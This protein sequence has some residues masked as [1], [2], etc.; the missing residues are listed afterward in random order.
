[1]EHNSSTQLGQ[2]ERYAFLWSLARLVIAALSLFF[3]AMPFMY[4]LGLSGLGSFL[5]LFWLVSGV[6][7]LYLGYL[8]YT[9]GMKVFGESDT[10]TKVLFLILVLSGLNLGWASIGGNIGMSIVGYGAFAGI[11]YKLTALVYLYT[12][13]TLWKE[14]KANAE[15]LFA[16][17]ATPAPQPEVTP[18]E[19]K[20]EKPTPEESI[21]VGPASTS[22]SVTASESTEEE[23]KV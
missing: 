19:K 23:K 4:R 21:P 1:M 13:Y 11:I 6:A 2:L 12:A 10:K 5:E 22:E 16:T 3:G 17:S 7:A 15:Q 20:E 9:R 8:W 14:W 18:V